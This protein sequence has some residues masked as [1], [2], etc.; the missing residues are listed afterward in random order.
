M[1]WKKTE[2]TSAEKSTHLSVAVRPCL[3]VSSITRG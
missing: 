3:C 2:F 1:K